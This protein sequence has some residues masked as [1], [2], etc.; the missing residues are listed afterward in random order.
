MEAAS[1]LL[2]FTAE[3]GI[4]L[5]IGTCRR[6]RTVCCSSDSILCFLSYPSFMEVVLSSL[7]AY[8]YIILFK[9]T[10]LRGNAM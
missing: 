7:L 8:W 2:W 1:I 6:L 4:S 9:Y 10:W 5:A 3:D